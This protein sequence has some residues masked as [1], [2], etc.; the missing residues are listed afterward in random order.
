VASAG[1][2]ENVIK[3][4]L[5]VYFC[6]LAISAIEVVVSYRD[7]AMPTLLA[8]LLSLAFSAATLGVMYFMHL[9]QERRSLFLSL[10]P[11]TIFVLLMMNA[12]WSDSL[13]LLH[14]RSFAH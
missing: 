7:F 3:K 9:G 6:L 2:S 14:M 11:V 10:I 4:Y 8:M 5:P 1:S 12:I 13:R